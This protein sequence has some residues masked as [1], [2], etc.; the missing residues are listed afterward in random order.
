[1]IDGEAGADP[2]QAIAGIGKKSGPRPACA[3][4]VYNQAQTIHGY[5]QLWLLAYFLIGAHAL[6]QPDRLLTLDPKVYQQDYP[7]LRLL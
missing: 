1:M 2:V 7:E 3:L 6:V 5:G 4:R